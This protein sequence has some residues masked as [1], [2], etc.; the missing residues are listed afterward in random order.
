M[1]TTSFSDN[2]R[3]NLGHILH[4]RSIACTTNRMAGWWVTKVVSGAV[5]EEMTVKEVVKGVAAA[6]GTR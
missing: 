4:S 5:L 6:D 3:N 2:L 1:K